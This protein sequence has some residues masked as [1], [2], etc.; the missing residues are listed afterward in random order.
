VIMMTCD[1]HIRYQQNLKGQRIALIELSGGIGQPFQTI[2]TA[3]WRPQRARSLAATRLSP[4]HG[5]LFGGAPTPGPGPD[6]Q[7]L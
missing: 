2:W 5:R 3:S 6:D 1:Q 4:G 7:H